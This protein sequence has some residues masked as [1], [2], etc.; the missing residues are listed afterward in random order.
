MLKEAAVIYAYRERER[1]GGGD[2]FIAALKACYARIEANPL[3]SQIRFGEF[4]HVTLSRL[5]YRL[6]Y[7]VQGAVVYVVQVR[8]TSRRP[9]KKFGP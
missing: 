7:R 8:H 3:G 6:V 5:R 9:T 4:R 2:R 1:K